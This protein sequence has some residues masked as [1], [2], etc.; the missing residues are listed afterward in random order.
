[1]LRFPNLFGPLYLFIKIKLLSEMK[2]FKWTNEKVTLGG[3]KNYYYSPHPYPNLS[4]PPIILQYC[5]GGNITSF[6]KKW[7]NGR[8][9]I[10]LLMDD[11]Q[12]VL[13]E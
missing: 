12:E 1:M 6:G 10:C 3:I 9:R 13:L 5:E 11:N 2:I 8:N 7:S 4:N